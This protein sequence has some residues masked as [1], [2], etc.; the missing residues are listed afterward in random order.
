MD[1]IHLYHFFC[2]F[3]S[4][5]FLFPLHK[6]LTY[7]LIHMKLHTHVLGWTQE[8]ESVEVEDRQADGTEI[9]V[10]FYCSHILNS[11][12]ELKSQEHFFYLISLTLI[13][14]FFFYERLPLCHDFAKRRP[15]SFESTI[16]SVGWILP[17]IFAYYYL[18]CLAKVT[19][20]YLV[21]YLMDSSLSFELLCL[22]GFSLKRSSLPPGNAT[23][24]AVWHRLH[25]C[26]LFASQAKNQ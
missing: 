15:S 12:S 3:I 19:K 13:F 21:L 25:A 17:L 6:T 4:S 20:T 14:F 5:S 7:P 16:W 2:F 11:E 23:H 26:L 22:H 9:Y 10:W 24:L 18:F 8:N 1:P